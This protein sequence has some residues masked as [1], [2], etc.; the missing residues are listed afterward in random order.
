MRIKH[1]NRNSTDFQ[2]PVDETALQEALQNQLTGQGL[3]S[4]K[5]LDA[6]FFNNTF[7]VET[8]QNQYILKVAPI[9]QADVFYNEKYLMQREQSLAKILQNVSHLIPDYLS[10]F[11]VGSRDAFL[12]PFVKG[13]LWHDVKENLSEHENSLLWHQLG[14]F[15]KHIHSFKGESFGYPPPCKQFSNWSQFISDNVAGM[16]KD[17]KR[18]HVYIEEVRQYELLLPAFYDDLDEVQSIN[19]LHGDLWPRNIIVDG[20]NS[21]IEIKAVLDAERA[22]WGDP[23]CDWVLIMYPLPNAFWDGYGQ[24]IVKNAKPAKVEIYKGMYFLLNIIEATRFKQINKNAM[25]GLRLVNAKLEA[26]KAAGH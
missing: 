5:E 17:A 11:K 26:F 13:H 24:N 1:I 9:E 20:C 22:F 12:Q 8:E 3:K 4:V 10:F 19:L 18:L 15:A 16:I 23:I 6:G 2:Q 14:K 21:S 25:E 7:K